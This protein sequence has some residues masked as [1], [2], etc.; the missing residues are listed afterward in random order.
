MSIAT[1]INN[2]KT[3]ISNAYASIQ[4]KGGTI[5]TNKNTENLSSAIGSITTGT[6][7]GDFSEYFTTPLKVGDTYTSGFNNS[8]QKIP[9]GLT[10]PTDSSYFF[11]YCRNLKNVSALNTMT[12]PTSIN[13]SRMFQF[14]GIIS[15][16]DNIFTP[17]SLQETFYSCSSLTTLPQMNTSNCTTMTGFCRGCSKITTFPTY[18]TS[19]VQ[20]VTNMCNGC[21]AL[22]TI[23]LLDWHLVRQMSSAFLNCTALTTLGGFQNFG[24]AFSTTASANASSLTLVLTSSNNLTEQSLINVLTNLYDIATKGV[25]TQTVQLGATNLAKLT[26]EEG[27]SA[28]T[29]AQ[30]FGW[31]IS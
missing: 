8:L 6:G 20:L 18:D 12:I 11:S 15:I 29:Q 17:T 27:Q 31:T 30:N 9:E 4:T 14:S 7:G 1:E 3:N 26:S 10:L 24:Q 13:I 16:P 22:T 28:L 25:K 21:I 19:K 5:P 23:P 2:L